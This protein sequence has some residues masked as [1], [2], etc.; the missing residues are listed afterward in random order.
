V[1]G[2]LWQVSGLAAAPTYVRLREAFL[3]LAIVMDAYSI[4]VR[5][6]ELAARMGRED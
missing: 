4:T 6:A 3:Y 5:G 1:R 2:I